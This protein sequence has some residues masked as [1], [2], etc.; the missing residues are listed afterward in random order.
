MRKT[1][2]AII[3]FLATAC[4]GLKGKAPTIPPIPEVPEIKTN[5]N[6]VEK[7]LPDRPRSIK[8]NLTLSS[9]EELKVKSGQLVKAGEVLS[10]RLRERES[11]LERKKLLEISLEGVSK[12][13]LR[14]T[15]PLEPPDIPKLPKAN[16]S[17]EKAAIQKAQLLLE[18]RAQIV[19]RQEQL[20]FSLQN[21][22]VDKDAIAHE[23]AK[24]RAARIEYLKS[25]TNLE[26][27]FSYLDF[28]QSNREYEKYK[29]GLEHQKRVLEIQR[30]R[31]QHEMAMLRYTEQVKEQQFRKASINTQLAAIEEKIISLT[32]VVSP[33]N[34]KIRKITYESQN[35]NFILAVA[36][37]DV[38]SESPDGPTTLRK[39]FFGLSET[40]IGA[41]N[42]KLW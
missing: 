13:I 21:F 16:F 33:F 2:I 39:P 26:L 19:N 17:K 31:S 9:L 12:N 35:N 1:V 40:T 10:D 32:A 23:K 36:T 6:F 37:L 28:A 11:L 8:I 42:G 14:P 18:E 22:Q 3:L 34:G 30:Q 25:K 7:K 20:I 41:S 5:K 38:A 27:A 15:E 24:L 29:H 4:G